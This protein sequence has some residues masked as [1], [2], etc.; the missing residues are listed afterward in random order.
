MGRRWQM[1][2]WKFN[3]IIIWYTNLQVVANYFG[4]NGTFQ[5]LPA[6]STDHFTLRRRCKPH[7]EIPGKSCK[8]TILFT[9][10]CVISL[11]MFIISKLCMI[12][13]MFSSVTA[14][15]N[16]W[17]RGISFDWSHSGGCSGS[18]NAYY[19]LLF[20]VTIV[21]T[22]LVMHTNIVTLKYRLSNT[23]NWLSLK[24]ILCPPTWQLGSKIIWQEFLM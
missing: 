7:P 10:T 3:W 15:S 17:T 2:L 8:W 16:R 13:F 9:E 4:A 12:E 14:L 20:Q 19:V 23:I 21:D 5:L 22:H 6:F 1:C 18:C 11:R 24:P